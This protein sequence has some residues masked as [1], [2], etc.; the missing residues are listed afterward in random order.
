MIMRPKD[1]HEK[2]IKKLIEIGKKHNF[3]TIREYSLQNL[4]KLSNDKRVDV[5]W[6]KDGVPEYVFEVD[7]DG[8]KP[9]SR[10]KIEMMKKINPNCNILYFIYRP[11][12]SHTLDV[13]YWTLVL[14]FEKNNGIN[15]K[16]ELFNSLLDDGNDVI[17]TGVLWSNKEWDGFVVYECH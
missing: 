15:I 17:E 12:D 16:N 8:W 10:T 1:V 6:L 13:P 9:N 11:C 14:A 7:K 5:A 2:I 3:I 4:C